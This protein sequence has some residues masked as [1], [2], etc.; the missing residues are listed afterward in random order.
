MTKFINQ[1]TTEMNFFNIYYTDISDD[2]LTQICELLLRRPDPEQKKQVLAKRKLQREIRASHEARLRLGGAPVKAYMLTMS[3]IFRYENDPP[4]AT[5]PHS[6]TYKYKSASSELTQNTI[7]DAVEDLQDELGKADFY[8]NYEASKLIWVRNEN[9]KHHEYEEV[10][11][12]DLPLYGFCK[13]GDRQCPDDELI[14]SITDN[15]CVIEGIFAFMKSSDEHYKKLTREQLRGE[16]GSSSPSINQIEAWLNSKASYRNYASC[17]IVDPFRRKTLQHQAAVTARVTM[18]FYVNHQDFAPITVKGIANKIRH[19]DRIDFAKLEQ[20][21]SLMSDN[22]DYV[23]SDQEE[24]AQKTFEMLSKIDKCTKPYVLVDSNDLSVVAKSIQAQ[25]GMMLPHLTFTGYYHV[26][27]FQHPT[28][29]QIIMSA[30]DFSSRKTIADALYEETRYS[31]FVFTNQTYQQLA[32]KSFELA[33]GEL[34]KDEVGPHLLDILENYSITPFTCRTG[35]HDLDDSRIVSIDGR[36]CYASQLLRN[37]DHIPVFSATDKKQP[38]NSKKMGLP[39]GE[40]YVDCQIRMAGGNFVRHH[41]WYPRNVVRHCLKKGYITKDNIT[42]VIIA[43]RY[44]RAD[45]FKRWVLKLM[46]Q[47]PDDYKNLINYFIGG[48]GA[49]HRKETESAITDSF[50][51]AVAT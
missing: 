29:H 34:P 17:Y 31:G 41:G 8:A 15:Q 5:W 42:H 45:V 3:V 51:T 48:L 49:Q 25:T 46:E 4:D 6:T 22:Y 43:S 35:D 40:F 13:I 1:P 39:F 16:I 44:I 32:K 28:T 7:E 19:H 33:V 47:F 11:L 23:F 2:P 37:K 14:N 26:D 27:M 18:H 38:Y 50:E 20:R 10:T 12:K 30:P 36:S 24:P 21:D 9:I